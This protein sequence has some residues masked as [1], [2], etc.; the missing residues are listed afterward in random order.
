[1]ARVLGIGGV[2]FKSPDPKALYEWYER[3]LGIEVGDDPGMSFL[4]VQMPPES[5]TVWSAFNTTTTYLDPSKKDFM[6]NFVVDDLE[7]ALRQVKEGGAELIGSIEEYVYGRF[8]WF[9]DP[10]GNKIELWEPPRKS[11]DDGL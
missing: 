7:G 9:M 4:P 10:D 6:I 1:M 8:G 11:A 5:F 2:F 3:H